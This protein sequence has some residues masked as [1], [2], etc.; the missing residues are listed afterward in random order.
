MSGPHALL[1]GTLRALS[2]RRLAAAAVVAATVILAVTAVA[3]MPLQLLPEIRYPQVR[4]ISD[5]PGQTSGVIEESVNEPI[6]AA[7]IGIPGIVRAESRSGDGRSYI[8]LFFEPGYDL[9][10]ALRDVSQAVQRAQAQIPAGFPEPVV[11]ALSTME[12]PSIQIAVGSSELS[13]PE[14]RQRLRGSLLPRLRAIPGVES[15]YLGREEVPELVVDIDPNRQ[16]SARVPLSAIESVL[17]QATEPPSSST[18]RTTGF[19]GVAVL[20]QS[21]WSTEWLSAQQVPVLGGE[22]SVPLGAIS[23]VHMAPSEETLYTR[24]DGFPA[25]IVSI[26]RSPRA[27]ALRVSRE[28]RSVLD[29]LAGTTTFAGLNTT[30]LFDDA[31]VTGSAVRSAVTAVLGGSILAMLLLFVGLRQRRYTPLVAMVVGVSLAATL[32]TL[33]A[34]GHSLNLLTLAGLLLS[35]GLGLDYAIIYFDRLDR[36]PHGADEP[37]IR[38]MLEVV[39]PLLGA[40]LTTLAAILPFLLVSGLVALLFRPL[41]VTVVIAGIFSFTFAVILLPLFARKEGG[42]ESGSLAA[43][44]PPRVSRSPSGGHPRVAALRSP[45]IAWSIAGV[46]AL[47]LLLGGR[48]LPFEVLPVVDDGFVEARFTH[49]VGIPLADLDDL[50]RIVEARLMELQ[51]TDALFT[52]V[53]GYFREGLPAF[54]PGQTDFLVRVDTRGAGITSEAWAASARA[55]VA[56]LAIP[57]LRASVI[58]PRIRGVQTR[59]TEADLIVV[60]TREDGNLLALGELETSIVELLQGTPGLIDVQRI[61]SGVSP[62][63]NGM[64][65]HDRIASLG[66]APADLGQ[67]MSYF[68]EGQVLRQRMEGGEPLALRVRYDRRFAGGPDHLAGATLLV[69]SG[70]EVHL[71]DIVDF[72]LVEEPTHIE[73]REGQRVVRVSGQLDPAGPGPGAVGADVTRA[74]LAADLPAGTSWWLE[75]EIETLQETT[76]TFAVSMGLALLLVLTLLVVQYGSIPFALAGLIS[77]PLSGS[78]AVLLLAILGRPLDGMVLAGLLI[79]VGIVANNVILVLSQAR[80]AAA[81]EEGLPLAHALSRAADDRLRPITLTVLSTVLGMSPLLLGGAEVFGLLQPLAI[82]LT[83]TLLI[84][85]PLAWLVLPGLAISLSSIGTGSDSKADARSSRVSPPRRSPT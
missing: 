37:H 32:V 3:R 63:W 79:A 77:I 46:L 24:L 57:G 35:V 8:D 49:P 28:A 47:V 72:R 7:L 6:E 65:N 34:L 20:G 39:A 42:P 70:S 66:L 41:I 14:I 23:T 12:D 73:R 81:G 74:M 78:G 25:V 17:M 45:V 43:S 83:G 64:P 11:F 84:S 75:G 48:A 16:V 2:E 59:L 58:P 33:G 82:A 51:G 21:G 10:R 22:H 9:D 15:V 13:V 67:S 1:Q 85:I 40:L 38:A 54:R 19:E 44:H 69:P 5:I 53:G 76:R 55:A 68:L 4:I 80:E 18:M 52:T 31:V 61:R 29:D 30:V 60:L 50:A 27:H 36:I 26:H 62:R 71:S 56:D